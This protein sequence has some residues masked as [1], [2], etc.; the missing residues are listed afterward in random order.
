MADFINQIIAELW[1][2]WDM[3]EVLDKIIAIINK[4]RFKEDDKYLDKILAEYKNK[5]ENYEEF[6][7]AVHKTIEAILEEE[8][9]KFQILSRI[10]TPESL[11]EKLLRKREKGLFYN[12]IEEVEDIVGIRVIFYTDRDKKSFIE[13][14]SK[15]SDGYFQIR[16]KEKS[17]GYRATHIIMSFGKK[18]IKL[19]EYKNFRGLRSEVQVTSMLHHAWAEIEHDLI[20]KDVSGLRH[21]NPDKYKYFKKKIIYIFYK[22]I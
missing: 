15:E 7:L 21:R 12:S 22:Y 8:G 1:Y 14:M 2:N 19:P 10:K 13:K 6:R 11:I 18:R 4:R 3:A 16:E 20:Y 9:Y 17:S 5:K